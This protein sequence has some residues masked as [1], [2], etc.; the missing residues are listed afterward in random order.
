MMQ[1]VP[2]KE[3]YRLA[4][5][6]FLI[7]FVITAGWLILPGLQAPL[8]E[9]RRMSA[10]QDHGI[11]TSGCIVAK[12]AHEGWRGLPILL[13]QFQTAAGAVDGQMKVT[14]EFFAQAQIGQCLDVA[15]L[16]EDPLVNAPQNYVADFNPQEFWGGQLSFI[17]Y[18]VGFSILVILGAILNFYWRRNRSS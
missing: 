12:D 15:Y 6:L 9:S 18:V 16:P 14:D 3:N 7:L 2:R 13:Y 10:L 5:F 17:P 1:S 4:A 8:E 11:L